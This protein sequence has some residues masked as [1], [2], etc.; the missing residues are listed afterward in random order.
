[1]TRE[2]FWLSLTV[3]MRG[4]LGLALPRLVVSPGG[5]R[6]SARWP[7]PSAFSHR[8]S[9]RWR[10]SRSFDSSRGLPDD[11][12]AD[13]E[14][15][16]EHAGR[17]QRA[18]NS[19]ENTGEFVPGHMQQARAGPDPIIGFTLV[20]LMEQHRFDRMAETRRGDRGHLR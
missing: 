3:F 20:E 16:I 12:I 19:A 9:W 4:L 8:P 10:F 2:L 11:E 17:L 5:W 18:V 13:L 1:M 6:V 15:R 7:S 14:A